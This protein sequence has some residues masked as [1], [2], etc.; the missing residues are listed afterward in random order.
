MGRS[1]PLAAIPSL[2][3]AVA[4]AG[5]GHPKRDRLTQMLDSAYLLEGSLEASQGRFADAVQFSEKSIRLAPGGIRGYALKANASMHM[6]DYKGAAQA[7]GKM[8]SLEA[9]NP[10]IRM[11]LGDMEFQ[12]GDRAGAREDWQKALQL[13]PADAAELREALGRRLAGQTLP[14]STP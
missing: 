4:L 1:E 12:E 10:S 14:G 9:D 5:P 11:R 2:E 3:Q 7:L 6:K 8:A 13:A